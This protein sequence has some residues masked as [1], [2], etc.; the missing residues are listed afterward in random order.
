[1]LKKKGRKTRNA[2]TDV[3]R[4]IFAILPSAIGRKHIHEFAIPF[5]GMRTTWCDWESTME[6]LDLFRKARCI[7]FFDSPSSEA[8]DNSISIELATER[9]SCTISRKRR[10]GPKPFYSRRECRDSNKV[11]NTYQCRTS[12]QEAL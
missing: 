6:V 2:L 11:R 5:R 7:L 9:G 8:N 3:I 12:R 4:L 10:T 1:M